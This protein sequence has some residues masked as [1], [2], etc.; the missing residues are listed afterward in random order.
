MDR[1][2]VFVSVDGQRCPNKAAAG[3]YCA[4]HRP[5]QSNEKPAASTKTSK[6][7]GG[8]GGGGG[9]SIMGRT[10]VVYQKVD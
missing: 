6:P 7:S 8:G 4:E 5:A 10:G 2:C 9:W 1:Q 3:L